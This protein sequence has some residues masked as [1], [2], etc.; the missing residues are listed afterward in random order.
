MQ[1]SLSNICSAI[2]QTTGYSVESVP[3]QLGND[4]EE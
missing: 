1:N 4:I 3:T 2:V